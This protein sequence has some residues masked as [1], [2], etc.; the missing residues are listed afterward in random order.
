M[1]VIAHITRTQKK[2]FNLHN[3]QNRN[4][5]NNQFMLSV[6]LFYTEKVNNKYCLNNSKNDSGSDRT[7]F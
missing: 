2:G 5:V 6:S 7:K 4:N 3:E 1:R